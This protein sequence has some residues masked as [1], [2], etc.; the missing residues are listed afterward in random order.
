M[1]F[2][3]LS[4]LAL[5]LGPALPPPV[6]IDYSGL[7][8]EFVEELEM[9]EA[10]A[11]SFDSLLDSDHFLRIDFGAFDIRL[12][13]ED[14]ADKS[15]AKVILQSL[16]DILELQRVW[17]EWTIHDPED[18]ERIR[19]AIEL[20]QKKFVK[21]LSASKFKKAA[22]EEG[23]NV[24]EQLGID[25]EI[26]AAE[27][28]LREYLG[29]RRKL[30][31][32]KV[33]EPLPAQIVLVPTREQYIKLASFIGMVQSNRRGQLWHESMARGT[34]FWGNNSQIVA[35]LWAPW[36]YDLDRPLAQGQS[37][38]EYEK[39]GQR[40]HVVDR[41]AA[42][43][44]WNY[45]YYVTVPELET[46]LSMALVVE[47]IGQNSLT[48]E[49]KSFEWSRAGATTEPYTRFVPGGNPSGGTL[50]ARQAQAGPATTWGTEEAIWEQT[51]AKDIFLKALQTSQKHGA[52]MGK[53]KD[54]L[55]DARRRSKIAHFAVTGETNSDRY[56]V[57]APFLGEEA[58]EAPI[59]PLEYLDDYEDFFR[60]YRTNFF[61]WL[62]TQGGGEDSA[63][64]FAKLLQA[65]AV[66][67]SER[68]FDDLVKE[69]YGVELADVDPEK[70]TLEWRYLAWLEDA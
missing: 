14:A 5:T 52:K 44:L 20:L 18:L 37:M 63:A 60:C 21:K 43:L 40:E 49:V 29:S 13:S 48:G 54:E 41:A 24:F 64:L 31:D 67:E 65:S 10:Q 38:N 33:T 15:E 70:D 35:L 16:E 62:R 1:I 11:R 27:A 56:A 9:E 19:E 36:P 3:A 69:I 58:E 25:E 61:Y 17:A 68:S 34:S 47:V 7:A 23:V 55:D 28:T 22:R 32:G 66:R 8:R 42:S 12:P 26:V 53:D 50:P 39:T 51:R 57:T 6:D 46:A 45:F 30:A 2:E 4:T 59:P